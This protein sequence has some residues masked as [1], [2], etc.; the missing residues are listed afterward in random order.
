V[1]VTAERG[2]VR[3][4]TMTLACPVAAGVVEL[5]LRG[6]DAAL[7]PSLDGAI[8]FHVRVVEPMG[9]HLLLTGT[10]LDQPARVVAPATATVEPG[11]HVGLSVD[12]RRLTWIDP[13]TGKA[14]R[15]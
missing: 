5:G 11:G 15:A 3:L 8:P 2:V 12:A 14:I 1:R 4:G 13:E 9:S 7:A 6:E 10:I